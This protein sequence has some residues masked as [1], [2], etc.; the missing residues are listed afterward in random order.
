MCS[1]CQ[2][3][4]NI[5]AGVTYGFGFTSDWLRK[6]CENF[7]PID[8]RCKVEQKKVRITSNTLVKKLTV[9]HLFAGFYS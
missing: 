9:F 1:G 3:R 8:K 2:A 7:K 6:W 4:E 5:F